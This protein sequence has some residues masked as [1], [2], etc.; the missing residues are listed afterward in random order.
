MTALALARLV[1]APL[2]TL[3]RTLTL[4]AAVALLG[5]ML[6][7]I[8]HSLRT[9]TASATRSVP[10]DWQGPVSSYK[11]AQ[12]VAGQVSKQPGILQASPTATAP[13]AG[14]EHKAPLGKI[15]AGSGAIMAIPPDYLRHIKTFRFLRGSLKPGEV[16]LDQQLAATMQAHI[17]DKILL[18]PRKG[19]KPKPE[20]FRVSGVAIVTS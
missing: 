15:R 18:E 2:A 16:V 3:I 20:P 6:L 13:F 11:A 4:A 14:A 19:V 8:G 1:R 5:A 9:M 12:K 10:L 17:G 7:F